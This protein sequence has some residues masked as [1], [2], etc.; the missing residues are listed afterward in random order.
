MQDTPFLQSYSYRTRTKHFRFAT[1]KCITSLNN[2]P[3]QKRG[4]CW[5]WK[6]STWRDMNTAARREGQTATSSWES[7]YRT[8]SLGGPNQWGRMRTASILGRSRVASPHKA[9]LQQGRECMQSL[10]C[11]ELKAKY[12]MPSVTSPWRPCHRS[13]LSFSRGATSKLTPIYQERALP[14]GQQSDMQIWLHIQGCS[15]LTATYG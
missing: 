4:L 15:S 8:A 3:E 5:L 7:A 14:V 12:E 10:F 13:D 11:Q 1:P 9:V 6:K 2:H